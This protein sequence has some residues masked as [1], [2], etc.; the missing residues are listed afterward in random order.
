MK[1]FSKQNK[2]YYRVQTEPMSLANAKRIRDRLQQQG[3]SS[4]LLKAR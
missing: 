2:T 4:L 3:Q 1:T